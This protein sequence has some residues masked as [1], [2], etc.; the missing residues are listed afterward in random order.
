MP[1]LPTVREAAV[2]VPFPVPFVMVPAVAAPRL[3]RSVTEVVTVRTTPLSTF[4]SP[5]VDKVPNCKAFTVSLAVTVTLWVVVMT[6]VSLEPGVSAVLPLPPLQPVQ[7][8]V[9]FQLPVAL[10]VQVTA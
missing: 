10:E 3:P 8:P 1:V 4:T 6:A 9:T 7:V 5:A 2:T